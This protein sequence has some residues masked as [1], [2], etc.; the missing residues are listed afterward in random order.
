MIIKSISK[1]T[2]NQNGSVG[3]TQ[4]SINLAVCLSR[5]VYKVVLI[6]GNTRAMQQVI[7]IKKLMKLI[8]T[9]LW[10]N[11]LKTKTH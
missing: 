1:I 2:I 8:L 3:K 7:L 9:D 10:K 6:D 5:N 4:T 11:K